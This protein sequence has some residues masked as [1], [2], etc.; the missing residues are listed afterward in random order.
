MSKYCFEI[1][2]TV[3]SSGLVVVGRLRGP[4]GTILAGL[5][6]TNVLILERTLCG[7]IAGLGEGLDLIAQ[8][9]DP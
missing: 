2:P 8:G 3:R 9:T 4:Q 7:T 5:V 6:V 1:Q